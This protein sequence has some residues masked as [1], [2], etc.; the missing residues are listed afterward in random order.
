MGIM[1]IGTDDLALPD[2]MT[3]P[4]ARLRSLFRMALITDFR[5]RSLDQHFILYLMYVVAG[6]TGDVRGLMLACQPVH[7]GSPLVAV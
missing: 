3:G 7:A 1:A 5:L 2:G 6:N 4:P